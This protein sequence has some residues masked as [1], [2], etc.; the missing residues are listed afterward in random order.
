[1]ARVLWFGIGLLLVALALRPM[2]QAGRPKVSPQ[3]PGG[4]AA[5]PAVAK[6]GLLTRLRLKEKRDAVEKRLLLR[7]DHLQKEHQQEAERNSAGVAELA[8]QQAKLEQVLAHNRRVEQADLRGDGGLRGDRGAAT[9]DRIAPV[10]LTE[11]IGQ[12][13]Q[14]LAASRARLAALDA[15]IG[16]IDGELLAIYAEAAGE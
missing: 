11:S 6:P 16:S 13:Q 7:K 12:V 8:Q 15:E 10:L 2:L 4:R 9:V 3:S 5:E 14:R 1:M